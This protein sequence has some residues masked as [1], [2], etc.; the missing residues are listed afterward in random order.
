MSYIKELT[1]E[2]SVKS[3]ELIHDTIESFG[4]VTSFDPNLYDGYQSVLNSLGIRFLRLFPLN[5]LRF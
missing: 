3:S 4:V 2:L 1:T 5:L